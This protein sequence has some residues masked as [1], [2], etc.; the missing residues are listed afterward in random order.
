MDLAR[1]RKIIIATFLFVPLLFLAV[2][3]YIPIIFNVYLGFTEWNGV[4]A[5]K[6]VGLKNYERIFTDPQYLALFRNC[7][8]Y[9]IVAVPQLVLSFLLAIFV[10]GKFKGLAFFKGV[11]IFPYLLNGIIV[12]TIFVTF[13]NTNGT[14]NTMLGWLHLDFLQ[15]RWLEELSIVNPAVASISIWR[16]YGMSFI[17][18]FGALQAIPAEL[19]ESA[20]IDGCS[21]WQEI[22][23]I[24]VPFVK[25]VLF[26][27]IILSVSG[28]IQV[29]EVPYI[30]VRGINGTSTPVIQINQSMGQDRRIG[31]AAALSMVVFLVVLASVGLQWLVTRSGKEKD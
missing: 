31:F 19:Y 25:S 2:F 7:V 30:I 5:I 12:S 3:S 4:T 8:Y 18:F 26:I 11:L 13:F 6:W 14:L 9:L 17:M 27:N 29:Y 16:Y 10:N 1:Q 24:S 15:H 21:K 22:K 28:S 20:A 23:Y